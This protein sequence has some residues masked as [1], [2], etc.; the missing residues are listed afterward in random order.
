MGVTRQ[1][2][3]Y[4]RHG[5]SRGGETFPGSPSWVARVTKKLSHF[6]ASTQIASKKMVIWPF[7]FFPRQLALDFENQLGEGEARTLWEYMSCIT[8]RGVTVQASHGSIRISVLGVTVQHGF[9]T[10]GKQN[11]VPDVQ[12]CLSTF[13][14]SFWKV[15][16]GKLAKTKSYLQHYLINLSFYLFSHS[17]IHTSCPKFNN[18]AFILGI[19]W[20]L[21]SEHP[22]TWA[23]YNMAELKSALITVAFHCESKS[24]LHCFAVYSTSSFSVWRFRY[25]HYC[26]LDWSKYSV[27]CIRHLTVCTEPWRL[28]N[29]GTG[30][31]QILLHL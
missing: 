16:F 10:T 2:R 30:R 22:I 9:S 11:K 7:L 6:L 19:D 29:D 14:H 15:K 27:R 12:D 26:P 20:T 21:H 24:F 4:S 3:H 31:I 5:Q 1:I 8:A 25:T 28:C 23:T 17:I 18:R 13:D